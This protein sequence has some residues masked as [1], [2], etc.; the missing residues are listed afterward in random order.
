MK[1][2]K[3]ALFRE[4]SNVIIA[5]EFQPALGKD[6]FLGYRRVYEDEPRR[7]RQNRTEGIGNILWLLF[8]S[9]SRPVP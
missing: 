5:L 3:Y 8:M 2:V 1:A 7:N 4:A 6:P 9:K